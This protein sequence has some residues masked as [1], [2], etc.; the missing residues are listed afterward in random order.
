MNTFPDPT[1]QT[2]RSKI[3]SLEELAGIAAAARAE[4]RTVA[5]C[6]GVFDLVHLG[7]VRHIEAARQKGDLLIVTISADA[8][9]NKGPGRPIFPETIRAEMLAALGSV[10]YVGISHNNT[11]EPVIL[12]IRPSVYVKGSDYEN[13][14][15]DITGNIRN[16]RLA[17]EKHGGQLV[18]TK[19][20][21][22]S[23]SSLIN[24]YLDVDDPPLRDLLDRLRDGGALDAITQL[25]ESIR[26]YRVVMVGDTIVDEYHFV[27]PL[28][29][30][31]KDNIITTL[32]RNGEFFAGGVIAAANHIASFCKEVQIITA[33]GGD[34]DFEAAVRATLKP[35]V[36][37]LAVTIPG[38]PTTR[39]RR[40]IEGEHMRKLFEVYFMDDTP[41]PAETR[42]AIDDLIARHIPEA[43]VVITSDFGHGLIVPSTVD[44]LVRFS[45]FLAVNTQTNSGNLGYNLITKYP[46]ADFICLDAPEAR[47][48]VADKFSDIAEVLGK[49]L[50]DRVNCGQIIVTNGKHGCCHYR[51]G[52]GVGLVPAFTKTVVDTVGAGDAFFAITAPLA[53]AGGNIEHIACI[54]NAA[55][56]IKVGVV[57]HRNSVEKVALLKY[58]TR[59]LK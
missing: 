52:N 7:H 40:F 11:A 28:G 17:V 44:V 41:P 37:L 27:S 20:I 31:S 43:D 35:N 42:T 34:D 48:A 21:T 45:R 12:V 30:A 16:E 29:K 6:H 2:A 8:F 24:R 14:E 25:I 36:E 53:A 58:L 51:R 18:F 1:P 47:L 23:S 22:F 33:L 26:D 3:R 38:R 49:T 55:G 54:G 56:A 5:L 39:K 46:R 59:L 13:P 32:F 57:G 50:P 9:V 19:D 4:G 10:D 15:D